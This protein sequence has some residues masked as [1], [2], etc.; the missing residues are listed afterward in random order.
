MSSEIEK[1]RALVAKMAV[2]EPK[3]S[4][5]AANRAD[6]MTAQAAKMQ[7]ENAKLISEPTTGGTTAGATR[8]SATG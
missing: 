6:N 7:E 3:R 8:W 1:L 5:A 2:D 4:E